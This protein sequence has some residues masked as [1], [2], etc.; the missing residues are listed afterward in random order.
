M[1]S[2]RPTPIDVDA[3]T[4]TV[5]IESGAFPVLD[6]GDGPAVLLLHGFPDSRH[7]WRYQ[8]P[9]LA[10]AGFRVVAPDL[11]GF[12]DAPKPED[13]EAYEIARIVDDVGEILSALNVDTCHVVGHDWGAEVAW[14]LTERAP[15]VVQRLALLSV[16]PGDDRRIEA[17]ERS[18]YLWFFQFEGAAEERLRRDDWRLFR[19]WLREEGDFERYLDDLARPGALTAALDWYRA[20]VDPDPPESTDGDP[21]GVDCPTLGVWSDGDHHLTEEQMLGTEA[22]VEGP[23]RYERIEGA[24]HWLMLDEPLRVNDVLVDFLSD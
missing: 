21:S 12:G 1:T 22:M 10:D 2:A 15:D 14:H 23:W 4:R 20:N 8:A 7:L 6:C 24:S 5:T 11:R 16:G 18:W 13:V 19:E 17:W 3:H 9:A